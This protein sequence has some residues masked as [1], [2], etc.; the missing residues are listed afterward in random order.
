[1]PAAEL[2]LIVATMQVYDTA[3][4]FTGRLY[5]INSRNWVYTS[6]D[7]PWR[8]LGGVLGAFFVIYTKFSCLNKV[9]CSYYLLAGKNPLSYS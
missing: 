7:A 6:R 2:T 8:R 1:M 4:W 3:E 9:V 5:R